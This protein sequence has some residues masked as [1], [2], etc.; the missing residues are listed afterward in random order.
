MSILTITWKDLVLF[1]KDRGRLFMAFLLPLVFIL[2]FGYAYSNLARTNARVVGLP[3]V[4]LDSGGAM[5]QELLDRLN[6][7]NGVEVTLYEQAKAQDLLEEGDLKLVLTIPAGFSR[8]VDAGQPVVLKLV[9]RP[10]AAESDLVALSTVIDGVAKDLSLQ[11]QLIA[12][13]QQMGQMM[14]GSPG[15][16]EAF[17][18]DAAIEQATSQFQRAKTAPLVDVEQ[19]V[20]AEILRQRAEAPNAMEIAVPGIAVL[21]LFLSA[22]TTAL[23]IYSEKKLGTFRRLLSAPLLKAELLPGKM[24]PNVIVVLLQAVVIF[25]VGAWLMPLLGMD[26]MTPGN[27]PALAVVSLL[28]ALCSASLGV[29]LAAVCRTEG[30][31]SGGASAVLWVAGAVA[32]A[33][34][35]QFLMGDLLGTIGKVTPHYWAISAYSD[36]IVRGQ[37]LAGVATQLGVLALFTVA[38]FAI[39]VWRFRF[40]A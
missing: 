9:T 30:Q 11:N 14:S 16:G 21:F 27:L 17:A 2:A 33:F 35:P 28:V 32:G 6:P 22:G 18:A 12:A 15:G 5:S 24:L 36:I 10:D 19:Q 31:I 25:A 13:F 23:A 34:I 40:D 1:V 7:D 4:N 39:G 37:D 38:F 20:P 3:V 26:K 8:A 29:L